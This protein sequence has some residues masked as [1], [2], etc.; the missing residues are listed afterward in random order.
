MLNFMTSIP[1]IRS[2]ADLYGRTE[3]EI[4]ATAIAYTALKEV[5]QYPYI[6]YSI[7]E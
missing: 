6:L 5:R 1:E 7:G 2:I 3:H 4:D